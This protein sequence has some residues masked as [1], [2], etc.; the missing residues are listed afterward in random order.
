MLRQ[1]ASVF[2]VEVMPRSGLDRTRR[3][4]LFAPVIG[5]A[6]DRGAA[7]AVV[8]KAAAELACAVSDFG[9][10]DQI[11]DRRN[12][13]KELRVIKQFLHVLAFIDPPTKLIFL[14]AQLPIPALCTDTLNDFRFQILKFDLKWGAIDVANLEMSIFP[15]TLEYQGNDVV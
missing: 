7:R 8:R 5:V 1:Q 2:G 15:L 14:D 9:E 4:P 13:T 12:I 11:L 6:G 10:A 3:H